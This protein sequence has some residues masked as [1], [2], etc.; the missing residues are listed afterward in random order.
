MKNKALKTLLSIALVLLMAMGSIIPAFAFNEHTAQAPSADEFLLIEKPDNLVQDVDWD[1]LKDLLIRSIKSGVE[2]IDISSYNIPLNAGRTPN[3]F[4]LD[5]MKI[6]INYI[7]NIIYDTPELIRYCTGF[8]YSYSSSK[9]TKI[10]PKYSFSTD[11]YARRSALCKEKIN[12]FIGDLKN[13]NTVPALYKVLLVHDRVAAWTEYAYKDYLNGTLSEDVY[14]AYAVFIERSAVCQGYASAVMWCLDELGIECYIVDSDDMNHAWNKVCIDG[15]MYY[16]DATHDD[17][18]WDV[19]GRVNHNYFL[20]SANSYK[21]AHESGTTITDIDLN[22]ATSTKYETGYFWKNSKSEAQLIGNDI[23]YIDTVDRAIN[24]VTPDGTVSKVKSLESTGYASSSRLTSRGDELIY[25]NNLTLYSYNVKTG[26]TKTLYTYDTSENTTF[27]VR[28]LTVIDK[29]NYSIEP[30]GSSA[31]TSESKDYA[32]TFTNHEYTTET[33]S[34]TCTTDGYTNHTCKWCGD[35][36]TDNYTD[37]KGHT[38]ITVKGKNATC[39]TTGL[40]EGK[41]C[42]V[43][44]TVLVEQQ[45][46]PV[47]NHKY[48]PVVTPVTC[49]SDG[50]TTYTCSNCNDTYTADTVKSQGHKTYQSSPAIEATCTTDG[51]T[52]EIKC[53]TCGIVITASTVIKAKGHT[54]VTIKGTPATC[55]ETGLSDGKVCSVCQTATVEQTVIPKL[56]THKYETTVVPATC[57]EAGS[58]TYT[59]TVC[60][61]TQT[62]PIPAT[63]HQ[64]TYGTKGVGATCTEDGITP[65]TVCADCKTVLSGQEVIKATGHTEIVVKGKAATCTATGLTD[66][67][68]C[69]K[70]S[71]VLEAQKTI[72]KLPHSEKILPA[73]EATCSASGLTQGKQCSVCGTVTVAQKT[74][75]ALAH[76]DDDSNGVCD[77]CGAKLIDV[78]PPSNCSCNCHKTGFMGFIY[79]IQ[80]FFWKIFKT[81]QTCACG[82]SHY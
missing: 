14:A 8:S 71:I 22:D 20:V 54:E 68:K 36:Y 78:N 81:N 23:Y 24:K 9:F 29:C 28:G 15:E 74:I 77:N 16:L 48:I 67:K 33:V 44:N 62:K 19:G 79:K 1:S 66:G 30:F 80:R 6:S 42:S 7:G 61:D 70:C 64:N 43:C 63:G 59:C 46:I 58:T 35:S 12:D 37:A 5:F 21:T 51:K 40:T 41:K 3:Y 72:T 56:T 10:T 60:G 39:T 65:G 75:P 38:E 52:A 55:K 76:S 50:Y 26:V 34:A 82:V 18:V 32:V 69:S 11:E 4:D 49:T 27:K 47:T 25:T 13:N 53:E 2:S 73:V 31:F 57:T 17:P 45:T